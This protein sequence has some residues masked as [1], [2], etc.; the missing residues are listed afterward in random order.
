MSGTANFFP[1]APVPAPEPFLLRDDD[2]DDGPAGSEGDAD[3]AEPD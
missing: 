1:S 3:L 2:E